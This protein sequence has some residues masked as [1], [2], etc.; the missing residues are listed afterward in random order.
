MN[1]T[2]LLCIPVPGIRHLL[3][4]Q[5]Q[6]AWERVLLLVP[7]DYQPEGLLRAAGLEVHQVKSLVQ[8]IKVPEG[9]T[10]LEIQDLLG[11]ALGNHT[12]TLEV[13]MSGTSSEWDVAVA[14]E[15]MKPGVSAK[16]WRYRHGHFNLTWPESGCEQVTTKLGLEHT[17][18]LFSLKQGL[19]SK[20]QEKLLI[21]DKVFAHVSGRIPD[22]TIHERLQEA[23]T[24]PIEILFPHLNQN[25][26]LFYRQD[27]LRVW[28]A[29]ELQ[30]VL[31]LPAADLQ[32][33]V[34]I[35]HPTHLGAYS[36]DLMFVWKNRLYFGVCRF[37]QKG[38]LSDPTQL[39][40]DLIHL[41]DVSRR[42]KVELVP[43]VGV[44]GVNPDT[45]PK[46][47]ELLATF[48]LSGAATIEVLRDPLLLENYLLGLYPLV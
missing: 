27:W 6:L 40:P 29:G 31:N 41:T 18:S 20:W 28:L 19:E 3:F 11:K 36:P 48:G 43:F 22:K 5:R 39:I 14:A 33:G 38:K 45:L 32:S 4:L 44:L 23:R 34:S 10:Q 9:A 42:W 47:N 17:V 35:S 24:D 2:A 13:L 15:T 37:F 21:A 46:L 1:P 12:G 25:D 7:H 26:R 30:A 8:L 16:I